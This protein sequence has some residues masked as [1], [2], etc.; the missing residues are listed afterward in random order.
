MKIKKFMLYIS[1][2]AIRYA[3][4]MFS[5]FMA[6]LGGAFMSLAEL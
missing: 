3:A 2:V 1:V 5:G 4:V 6:G